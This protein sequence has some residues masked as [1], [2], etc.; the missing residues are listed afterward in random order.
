MCLQGSEKVLTLTLPSQPKPRIAI[1][2]D[3]YPTRRE[4]VTQISSEE[5]PACSTK[6]GLRNSKTAEK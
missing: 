4:K 3:S 1:N 6:S 2:E 5:P